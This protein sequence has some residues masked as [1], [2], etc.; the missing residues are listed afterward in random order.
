M[1]K[2]TKLCIFCQKGHLSKEHV[3]GDWLKPIF[4]RDATTTHTAGTIRPVRGLLAKEPLISARSRPGHSG[5]KKVRVVC[6]TCNNGWMSQLEEATK[7][8]LLPLIR[9]DALRLTPDIQGQIATWATKTVICAEHVNPRSSGGITQSERTWLMDRRTPPDH[10]FVWIAAY[11]DKSWADL[12]IFQER[13]RLE[14]ASV[15]APTIFKHYV[16]ATTFG[17]GHIL[18]LVIGTE[19]P[20]ADAP[21]AQIDRR[22][23]Q[24]IWPPKSRSLI[25]PPATFLKDPQANAVAN[26]LKIG[27]IFDNS[28]NPLANWTF[29]P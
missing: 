21:L 7:P 10:W 17:M 26:V 1:T 14:V 23:L 25:W 29:T 18:F 13:G 3:F 12:G 5:S 15:G 20:N 11:N 4:P 9:G 8:M 6:E 24:Q 2:K 27:N 22:T 19:F 16:H 28:R